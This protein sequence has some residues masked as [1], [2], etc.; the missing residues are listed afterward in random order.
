M[1]GEIAALAL[2]MAA[3]SACATVRRRP[4]ND[5]G[6]TRC[7]AAAADALRSVDALQC[8]FSARHGRWRTLSQESHFDVL[9]VQVEAF[10][11]RDAE[12]I[13]RRFVEGERATFSEILIYVNPEPHADRQRVRRVR[14]TSKAGMETLDL[15]TPA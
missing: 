8:W 4:S 6:V 3:I 15:E 5:Y 9:V 7:P 10:D 14:W 11:T 12:E 13:A 2:S 1:R